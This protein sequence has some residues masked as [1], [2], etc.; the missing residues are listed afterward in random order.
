[1]SITKMC[2]SGPVAVA[3]LQPGYFWHHLLIVTRSEV[4][5]AGQ[6]FSNGTFPREAQ[7]NNRQP[8]AD[9]HSSAGIKFD[10]SSR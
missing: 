4:A 5:K 7:G 1:M 3:Q 6:L 8:R 10:L 9:K 2:E